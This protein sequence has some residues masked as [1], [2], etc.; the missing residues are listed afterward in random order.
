MLQTP[1]HWLRPDFARVLRETLG[2]GRLVV[3]GAG[4]EQIVKQFHLLGTEA[5]A[6]VLPENLTALSL[7]N[8]D[9]SRID[10]VVW[11]YPN[12]SD[13]DE[14]QVAEVARCA[15]QIV[16][17]P[18]ARGHAAQRRPQLLARLAG[19][20]F[21][22]DYACDLTEL[23]GSALRLV[24][25]APAD[26]AAFVPA[27]EGAFARLHTRARALERSLRTRMSELEAADRHIARLEEKLL[28]LKEYRRSI[29]QLKEEK[30]ALRKSP[31]RKLGQV[32]LAPYLLPR[33]LFRHFDRARRD[34]ARGPSAV[35][36]AASKYQEWFERHRVLEAEGHRL[37]EKARTFNCQPLISIITPIFNTPAEWLEEMV[38]SVRAQVY[39]NWELLL[40]DDGSTAPEM[41][42]RLASLVQ[43]DGRIR[44]FRIENS[45]ISAASN[46]GLDQARGEWIGLLDHDDTL[47]PDALYRTVELLE[48]H[49]EADL[50][51]SD[52]DKL[53]DGGF[54]APLFK[55]AWSPDFFWTCN[56]IGHFTT[57]RRALLVE[58]G[59]FRSGYDFA[60]DYDLYIRLVARTKQIHHIARVL[61]HWRRTAV[62]TAD[63]V[64][65][66]PETLEAGRRAL[67]DGLAQGA[68]PGHV[69]IDWSTHLYRVRREL[70]AEERIAIIIPARDQTELLAR[71][72]QS[73][74][75][76]TNYRNYEIVVVDNESQSE[77]ARR[78]FSEFEHRRLPYPG[79]FNFS[80]INN[81]AVAQTQAPWLLFLN[82]D[83]EVIEPDWL[84]SMAEHVQR[85]EVGAVGAQLLYPDGTVQHGGVVLGV[86]GIAEH[87]FRGFPADYA[88]ANRQLQVTRNYSAVTG[89]CLLTRRDV[90]EQVGGFDEEQ[91]PVTYNDV[92]LCLKMRRAGYLIVYTP[93]AKLYHHESASRRASVEPRETEVMRQRWSEVLGADPYYNP[94][95]SRT[96]A[97]FSLGE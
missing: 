88:G 7:E 22:P 82:N 47:E 77:E 43:R 10:L 45:G 4:S 95:L 84:G 57:I 9:A 32:L 97:D 30:Q 69:A 27:V 21:T 73:I 12:A 29:K 54:D 24:R 48:N 13:G 63:N 62:S 28:K 34:S 3:V 83:T 80:A 71:C 81:F 49:P 52:E 31:E 26:G 44:S 1:D 92:D 23:D 56:Y 16:L 46:H 94:N 19:H 33:K 68:E 50:I 67:T 91:L 66:K 42:A 2:P 15:E 61:Y 51:Y 60:Q 78:Y 76:K 74:T 39:E 93:Y 37:R 65:R 85:R 6:C 64:R 96:R 87:A 5:I 75:T 72:I 38:E 53:T 8:G 40:I 55:P 58:A 90:F 20:G 79:P 18:E 86:G 36:E 11:V 70:V 25:A 14:S 17:L 41:P 89:A 59:A 35:T